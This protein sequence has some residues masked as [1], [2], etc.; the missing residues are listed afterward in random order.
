MIIRWDSAAIVPNTSGLFPEPEMPVNTVSR[1]F[2]ISMLTSFKLLT[3][4]P[5]PWI[6]LWRSAKCSPRPG[7][8]FSWPCS[9]RLHPLDGA[10]LAVSVRVPAAR[11]AAPRGRSL[12]L[13]APVGQGGGEPAETLVRSTLEA[14]RAGARISGLTGDEPNPTWRQRAD[15]TRSESRRS[16]SVEGQRDRRR[17]RRVLPE[18]GAG[19][20]RDLDKTFAIR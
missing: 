1:R 20:E 11:S 12:N 5:C 8:P 3:R 7:C 2:G 17:T 18:V 15:A 16:T 9:L 14:F 4:A 13:R 6:R 10:A 19:P